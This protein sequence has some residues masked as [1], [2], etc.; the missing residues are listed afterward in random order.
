MAK[1]TFETLLREVYQDFGGKHRAEKSV[2]EWYKV[3]YQNVLNE[4]VAQTKTMLVPGKMYVFKYNPKLKNKL[5]YY[6]KNPIVLSLGKYMNT[7]EGRLDL[8]VNLNFL[9]PRVKNL[10]LSKIFD[11]YSRLINNNI[12]DYP[13]NAILQRFL[14]LNYKIAESILDR[15]KVK[16]A[17]RSYYMNRRYESAVVAYEHW[18]KML[19]LDVKDIEGASIR[20]IYSQ[21]YNQY[22][23]R[24]QEG[25]F[26]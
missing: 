8:G 20:K 3:N 15:Y 24:N 14:P 21:Y 9:P 17:L 11:N 18:P 7:K 10:L 12:S 6:D 5:D 25:K 19:M 26:K 4:S 1:V 16:F 23:K 22:R 13:D 2:L